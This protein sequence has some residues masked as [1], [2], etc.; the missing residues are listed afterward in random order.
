MVELYSGGGV[1]LLM[2]DDSQSSYEVMLF[3]V[4]VKK[5]SGGVKWSLQ[6]MSPW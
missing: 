3:M 5:W 1:L 6:W 4:Y 2:V